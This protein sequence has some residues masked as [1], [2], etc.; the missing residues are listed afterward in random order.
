MAGFIRG[1]TI[2]SAQG[3]AREAIMNGVPYL[4]RWARNLLGVALLA[5]TF[6]A[7]AAHTSA[8]EKVRVSLFSWPGYA[9]WFIAKEKNLAP[10][11]DFDISII[12]NPSDSMSMLASGQMD[13]VSST[14]EY[15][16]IA[17]EKHV[18]IRVVA[19]TTTCHGSDNIILAP[20]VTSAAGVRGGRFIAAEG[21]LSQIYAGWWLK[22]NGVGIDEVKWVNVIMDAAA[23]AMVGGQAEAGEFWEPY[24]SQVLK[25]LKGSTVASNCK[26]PF[27][28]KTALLSDGMFMSDEFVNQHRDLAVAAMKAYWDAIAFWQKHPEEAEE[29]MA[30]GLKFD[31]A[32]VAR[33]V[34]PG[35]DRRQ[36]L[37]WIYDY[38]E[39]AGICGVAPSRPPL[40]QSNGQIYTVMRQVN[41]WWLKFGHMTKFVAPA[42]YVDCS[43]LRELY[44]SG[45]AGTPNDNF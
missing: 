8:A 7:T 39:A 10:E 22:Q 40:D 32:D 26:E 14:I 2:P 11:I 18:P 37:L 42:R 29:I 12:E 36:S 5:A 6:T 41:D 30:R 45:Y 43:L 15:G 27:W 35:G 16:P 25:G 33:I 1:A 28:T 4:C 34:G 13:I 24:G 38:G 20:G 31:K 19:L 21:G 17:A 23:A 3:I 44:E 9:W